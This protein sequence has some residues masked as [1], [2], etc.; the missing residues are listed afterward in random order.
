MLKP[1]LTNQ[2]IFTHH[3]PPLG[4]CVLKLAV[5]EVLAEVEV[6]PPLGGCVLKLSIQP[7]ITEQPSQPPLGGCVLKQNRYEIHRCHHA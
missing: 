6:Q 3:Q 5:V 7:E 2:R 1:C 4:G